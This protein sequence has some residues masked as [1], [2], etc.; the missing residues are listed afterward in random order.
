MADVDA[1]F[2]FVTS[3][4]VV[5]DREA[6]RAAIAQQVRDLAAEV[7]GVVPDDPGLLQEVVNLIEV[8]TAV[9][10][11]FDPDFL[12]LPRDVLINVMRNKQRYFAVQSS[13]GE[14]LPYFITIRNGDR[15]HVDLVQKGNEHVLTAR[16]SDARFFYRDD[17]KAPA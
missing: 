2:A 13:S 6:R 11:S 14:L 3:Q 17:V 7:G 8:P 15:E 4:G 16:F 9:R 12:T 1:Y 5:L 10:G